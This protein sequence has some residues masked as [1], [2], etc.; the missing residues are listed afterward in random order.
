MA[1]QAGDVADTE[2]MSRKGRRL[3]VAAALVLPILLAFLVVKLV[4]AHDHHGDPPI[5][6]RSEGGDQ[7]L[8]RSVLASALERL[9]PKGNGTWKLRN[10]PD[11]EQSSRCA[12]LSPGYRSSSGRSTTATYLFAGWLEVR[13]ADYVYTDA[14]NAA[15][16]QRTS[17]A[18]SRALGFCQGRDV[19]DGLRSVGYVAGT[20]RVFPSASVRTADGGRSYRIEI[21]ARYKGR[22]RD[23][24]YDSTSVR[25]GRLVL[26]VATLTA[27]PFQRMNE[28]FA[29]ELLPKSL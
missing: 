10:S 2:A 15:A 17:A 6:I 16:A 24:D 14:A 11:G 9:S 25:R 5:V 27:E 19:A 4:P 3:R 29:I 7:R 21:P 12:L 22:R 20:P 18:V 1:Q 26:V 8:T 13:L 23:W 28:A